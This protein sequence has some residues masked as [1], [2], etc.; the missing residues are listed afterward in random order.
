MDL[1]VLHTHQGTSINLLI[2]PTNEYW[3]V[4]GD[5][6]VC[7]SPCPFFPASASPPQCGLHIQPNHGRRGTALCRERMAEFSSF[8]GVVGSASKSSVLFVS[9]GEGSH[10]STTTCRSPWYVR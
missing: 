1:Y 2:R 5:G 7:I 6:P 10:T 9:Y 8:T 4:A 3:L